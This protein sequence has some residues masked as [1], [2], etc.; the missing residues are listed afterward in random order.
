MW[1][2]R[3]NRLIQGVPFHENDHLHDNSTYMQWYIT[4]TIRYILPI[5]ITS[6]DDVSS[7]YTSF[8]IVIFLNS[9]INYFLKQYDMSPDSFKG[10]PHHVGSSSKVEQFG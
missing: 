8:Y 3:Q 10:H 1:N 7:I 6:E 4:H 5:E 2:D 9:Y